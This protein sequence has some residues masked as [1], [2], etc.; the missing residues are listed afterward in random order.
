MKRLLLLLLLATLSFALVGCGGGDDSAG[1]GAEPGATAG[2]GSEASGEPIVIGA[3][4]GQTGFL[5]AYDGPVMAGAEIAVEEIN[6]AGGVLG[7]PLEIV[8]AD[9]KSE[10]EQGS[11]AALEIVDD[12]DAFIVTV[13]Y[14]FGG[15]AA[16]VA[17]ENGIPAFSGAGSPK[18]GKEGIGDMAFSIANGITESAVM[19]EFA[20]NDKGWRKPYIL[21]DTT[22]EHTTLACDYFEQRWKELAGEDSVAG[23]DTF[24]N[25]DASIASQITR[26]RNSDADFIAICS[27][28]PGAASAV[29]QVRGAGVDLP[30]IGPVSFDGDYWLDAVP[31]LS[32]FYHTAFGS[33]YG[34]DPNPK[35][36]ELFEKYQEN[37]GERAP[38]AFPLLGYGSVQAY[39]KAVEQAGTTDPAAVK[40]ALESFTDEELILGPTTYTPDCHVAVGRGMVVVE[41]QGGEGHAVDYFTPESVPE[42]I[43]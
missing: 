20:Y 6:E 13:D 11:V 32:D 23:K 5:E 41:I 43:C 34:D 15:P 38:S 21:Q 22:I 40:E 7:R 2:E 30:M 8:Y 19:A 12:A 10:I 36:N 24:Q 18:F 4:V 26:V 14:D 17:Q 42:T 16:R 25:A 28:N 37:T 35:V 3:P 33:I 29:R 1:E 31:N 39:A 27:F 9:T